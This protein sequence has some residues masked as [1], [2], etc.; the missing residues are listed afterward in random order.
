LNNLRFA[1]DG[2]L[3]ALGYDGRVWSL[4][5]TNGDGIEDTAEPF[6]DKPTL[7]V[8]VGMAWTTRGLYVSSK[9]KV[10]LLRDTDSDGKA[11]VEEIIASGWPGTDVGSGGVDATAVTVDA[12]G[13]VYFGLLVADYSNAYRL[14]K[15][16]EL[17][18]EEKGWLEAR[19]DK[20]GDPEE[21]VSL[22][23]LDSKRG[24]IQKWNASR[25]K[26]ETVA[27]GIRVPYSLAF[28]RAGD[29]FNTDQEGETW[30]P[31]GNPLDELNVIL[32]GKNY[33]FPPRHERWLPR[34]VSEPPVVAFGPQHQSSCGLVF[35]EPRNPV[36]S[37]PA[38]DG[39]PLPASPGQGRFGPKWWEGDAIVAGESRGKIWR[40]RLVKTPHG[41]VGKE[42][43]IA[44]LSMLTMDVAISPKGDLYVCCHSGGP[45]WGTGPNGPGKIFKISY[46]DPAAP[47]PVAAWANSVTEVRVAFDR[48]LDPSITNQFAGREIE[49][50]IN[51]R[52]GDRYEVLKPPY[53]VVQKQETMP[54][55]KLAILGAKLE[56]DDQT[57]VLETDPNLEPVQYALAIPGVKAPGSGGAGETVDVAY[58]LSGVSI[59]SSKY[60]PLMSKPAVRKLARKAGMQT[61][62]AAWGVWLPHPEMGVS[63]AFF[64]P[65][66]SFAEDADRLKAGRSI[67]YY[68]STRLNLP[69]TN[70][71]L[72]I[73]SASPFQLNAPGAQ[74]FLTN[75]HVAGTSHLL[76]VRVTGS[77]QKQA[78]DLIWK[79][80]AR[81]LQITYST[82]VDPTER[83]LPPRFLLAP[84]LIDDFE[85]D[86]EEAKP[87]SAAPVA[88][89]EPGDWEHGRELFFGDQ[90]KC[91]TCHR[92]RGA[93]Q[94]IGPD[95]SNLVYRDTASVLRDIR[96]PSAL[97][98]PDYVTYNIT[99][100]DGETLTG[101]IRA[102]EPTAL[103][104][105]GADGREVVVP[106]AEINDF[107]P[108]AVSLMPAGLID[109]LKESDVK[110]LLTFLQNEPPKHT[111]EEALKAIGTGTNKVAPDKK[112]NIVLVASKQDHGP[113]QHD[114]PAWQKSWHS[115]LGG[116]ANTTVAD[117]WQ[118]PTVEQFQSAGVIV[119]YYWNHDWNE[120]K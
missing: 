50:G 84:W 89:S 85:E 69:F 118:W 104:I 120:E 59:Y 65:T 74:I 92:I 57:L 29:L 94:T 111:R 91:S 20:G 103:R 30:M 60:K 18:P 67:S 1:P 108:S 105:F 10:S 113:G 14:R 9:G 17:K 58:D 22:Y 32:P 70:A 19:G 63:S 87:G 2:K 109:A 86:N 45:D 35:N 38:K 95:L 75:S 39:I 23:D 71:T 43:I 99:R 3:T 96:E 48:K 117:A 83:P 24:T 115:L 66:A 52:A 33:G 76:D 12:E 11:D 62:E 78:C 116:A 110:D 119:F 80:D 27:T 49:S 47:Q 7:S 82:D 8:P 31:N 68:V 93:G 79:S 73:K 56:N 4:K 100:T 81:D 88:E 21:E 107:R 26:L 34:L 102:N 5:D 53:Q 42:Y 101:F 77:L 6:W 44:R 72:H 97:I 106:R 112:V 36:N 98:N 61:T 28:N 16:K 13:N 54:R 37:R 90:L 46:T 40:V 55:S 15:R 41:Y 25:H 114:Y 51:V 64:S